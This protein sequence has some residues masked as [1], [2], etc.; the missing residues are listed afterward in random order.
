MQ[1]VAPEDRVFAESLISRMQEEAW[2][3]IDGVI[4]RRFQE[5]PGAD[6]LTEMANYHF[7]TGGKRIRALIPAAVFS[8]CGLKPSSYPE[9]PAAIEILHN[10]TLIHDDLQD[11]DETRRGKPTVWKA[12]GPAQAINSGDAFFFYAMALLGELPVSG[13][14]LKSLVRIF[15]ASSLQVIQGQAAEFVEKEALENTTVDGYIRVVKGKTGGLLGLP[16]RGAYLIAKGSLEYDSILEE[17]GNDLGTVFQIQDDLLDV[18]GEKGRGFKA[19]DLAEGKPSFL[20]VHALQHGDDGQK[21]RLSIILRKPRAETTEGDLKEGIA[22]LEATGA[23][24]A[25]FQA[26]ETLE[27]RL[28]DST[29][30]IKDEDLRRFLRGLTGVFLRPVRAYIEAAAA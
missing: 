18:V 22:I 5:P 7:D 27:Q 1:N 20:A 30:A 15:S 28:I 19:A 21:N 24:K 17:V 26:I 9:F 4:R 16:L 8:L 25:G 29:E 23:I 12:Y 14:V 3:S 10:A 6:I 11:G 2:Q 13:D